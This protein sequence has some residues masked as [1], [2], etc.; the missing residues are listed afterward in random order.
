M[1]CPECLEC[2]AFKVVEAV[3]TL[4]NNFGQGGDCEMVPEE[5]LEETTAQESGDV[6]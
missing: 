5:D 3:P 4:D 1:R 6:G 2:F